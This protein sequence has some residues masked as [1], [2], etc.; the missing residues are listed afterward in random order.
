MAR[1]GD[2]GGRVLKAPF[3]HLLQRRLRWSDDAAHRQEQRSLTP[4]HSLLSKPPRQDWL[5]EILDNENTRCFSGQIFHLENGASLFAATPLSWTSTISLGLSISPSPSNAG[6]C[7][8]CQGRKPGTLVARK[9]RALRG[10][11]RSDSRLFSVDSGTSFPSVG[12]RAPKYERE[13][14][15]SRM[16]RTTGF[17]IHSDPIAKLRDDDLSDQRRLR[18]AAGHHMIRCM[19][20]G[21]SLRIAATGTFADAQPSSCTPS[22]VFASVQ[23]EGLGAEQIVLRS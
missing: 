20:V 7:S 1:S 16:V 9:L 21:Y 4:S 17:P 14:S 23:I 12:T 19:R 2:D 8:V 15:D 5:Y 6:V 10:A 18:Q 11:R 3:R 22:C 13:N